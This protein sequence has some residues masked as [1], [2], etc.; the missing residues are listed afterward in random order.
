[1]KS[2]TLTCI[3][4]IMLFAA[5]DV[6]VQLAAQVG[7]TGTTNRIPIWTNSTTLGNSN[8]FQ[9]GGKV[10]VGTTSPAATLDVIGP[11]ATTAGAAA[12]TVLRV[13][14]GRGGNLPLGT[15][16]SAGAG[17][18][19]QLTSGNGGSAGSAPGGGLARIMI[20]GGTGG[21]CIPAST[22]CAFVAGKG[23]SISL[24]PGVGSRPGSILLA[25][26]GGR[27]GIGVA[28]PLHTLEISVG[29][30]TLADAW[31]SRSSRRFKTNIRPLE[32]ALEKVQQ[33]QGVSYERK[34]D[35]KREI[36]VIAEDVEEIVPEVVSRD[37]ETHD[38]EGV[39]YSRLTAL[40]IEAVKSQ[41]AELRM[42]H[43]ELQQLK[44]RIEQLTSNSSGQ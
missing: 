33:L 32:R 9:T 29:G 18:G 11:T 26:T 7:G 40:L 39:D 13:T 22:R 21:S 2:R 24:E 38:V 20:T 8:L 3:T 14:G 6:P 28:N 15:F 12:L 35:A 37:S 34:S 36:G 5:L 19:L 30:T 23:G 10:G 44:T 43:S 42:Q 25:P 16:G 4:A 1:M 41:Q 17:G 31:T 27:V